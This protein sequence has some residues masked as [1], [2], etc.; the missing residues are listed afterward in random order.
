MRF[1]KGN[2]EFETSVGYKDTTSFGHYYLATNAFCC[3]CKRH[4]RCYLK[5]PDGGFFNN[6]AFYRKIVDD[7][8]YTICHHFDISWIV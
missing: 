1:I 5:C 3:Y 7:I 8:T 4:G 6:Y 2:L